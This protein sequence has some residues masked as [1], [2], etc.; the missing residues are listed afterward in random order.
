MTSCLGQEWKSLLGNLKPFLVSQGQISEYLGRSMA[1]DWFGVVMLNLVPS[2]CSPVTLSC[3]E[4]FLERRAGISLAVPCLSHRA[5]DT[6]C[7]AAQLSRQAL[8]GAGFGSCML[9]AHTITI[10]SGSLYQP[11]ARAVRLQTCQLLNLRILI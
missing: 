9:Q 6:L 3:G 4:R 8:L 1:T 2:N 11:A 10:N 7:Q 5:E